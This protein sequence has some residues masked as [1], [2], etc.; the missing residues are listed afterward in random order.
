[1]KAA[2]LGAGI[3]GLSAARLLKEKGV[4]VTVY[5]KETTVGGLARTRFT[6][7]YLY[8]PYGGHIFN[9]KHPIVKEWVFNLLSQDKWKFTE[10]N[11]KI[12]LNGRY[13]SYPFELSLCELETEDA[14]NCIHDF[15]L[16]QYGERP[17]NYRDWLVWNFGQSICDYYMIPYNEKIWSYPLENMETQWME[18]KMPLPDKKDMIRSM[19]LKD[20]TER[21]M[22]HSTF[23]YPLEGG[24]QSLINAMAK[25]INIYTNTIVT[26][27]ARRS[28]K[29]IVN[30][31]EEYDYI[32]STLPLPELKNILKD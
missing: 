9:S 15:I 29:W 10:R 3:S 18:G 32:I 23:F 31:K 21:K 11:A 1:M 22:P 2:I 20:S 27:L 7:G 26:T 17:T 4:D 12:F 28:D 24:I 14:V 25:G 13:I 5:E 19:L 30:E 8:D 16:S 6:D